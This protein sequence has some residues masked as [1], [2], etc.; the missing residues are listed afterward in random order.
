MASQLLSK[1]K[2]LNGLQCPKLLWI[3]FNE[4]ER[5]TETDPVTQYIFDQGHLVGELAKE[6]FPSDIDLPTDNFM[7]N[8]RQAKAQF[9]QRKPLFE[10]G[11]LAG[12]IYSRIDILNP[13]YD[14]EWDIVEVKSSTSVKD[15]H[16]DDI[17][18]QKYC[19]H[20]VGLNINKCHLM[21]INNQYAK[22]GD[23]DPGQLFII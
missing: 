3:Q 14:D 15:V 8:I 7:D 12:K 10:A 13:V 5:I 9:T 20:Q 2:Y 21:Y 19:G 6:L 11:I 23:I 17:A 22:D 16:I 1:S 4:P 18:F